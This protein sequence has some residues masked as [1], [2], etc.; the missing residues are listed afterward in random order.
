[1][2]KNPLAYRHFATPKKKGTTL[3]FVFWMFVGI[4]CLGLLANLSKSTQTQAPK[5]S[6]VSQP[7]LDAM[8]LVINTSGNLCAEITNLKRIEGDTYQ[9]T[10]TRYRDGT[11]SA[12]YEVNAKTGEVK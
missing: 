2:N 7:T 12:A 9:V 3:H 6:K 11:G 5:T 1:M 8:A 10:C 4:A